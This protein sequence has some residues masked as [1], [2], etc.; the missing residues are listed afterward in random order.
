LRAHGLHLLAAV[1]LRALGRPIPPE[2]AD[3]ERRAAVTGLAVPALLRRARSAFDGRLMIM[4]GAQVALHYPEPGL[5]PFTDVDILADDA[6]AAQRAL[7]AAGFRALGPPEGC[8]GGH[9]LR[10]LAWP[11]LP[12]VIEMHCRLHWARGLTPPPLEELFE[13]AEPSG[14][15]IPGILAPAASHHALMLASHAWAH[16]PLRRLVDVI[17]VAAVCQETDP[18]TVRSVARNWRCERLW[19]TTQRAVDAVIYGATPPLALRL[20]A[21]HLRQARERTVLENR[22]QRLA[23]PAWGLSPAAAP[24]AVLRACGEHLHRHHGEPWRAKLVRTSRVVRNGAVPVS[25]NDRR[26]GTASTRGTV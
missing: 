8:N 1:R 26:L 14:L 2:L 22:I 21:R 17:D 16:E 12:I 25:E 7:V 9:H 19:L 23:A 13:A 18:A 4:K 6:V 11:G 20:W 10:P 15:G 5:R 24:G 3:L